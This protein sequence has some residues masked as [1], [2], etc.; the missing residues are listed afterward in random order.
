[1]Q[2]SISLLGL[3]LSVSGGLASLLA[4]LNL[5][6]QQVLPRMWPIF[7]GKLDKVTSESDIKDY[8]EDNSMTGVEIRK[9][10]TL[11]VWQKESSAFRVSVDLKHKDE[12]MNAELWPGKVEVCDWFC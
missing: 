12:I 10:D 8:L 7:F 11:K 4:R 1:M 9:L 6:R 5:L 2:S 3:S